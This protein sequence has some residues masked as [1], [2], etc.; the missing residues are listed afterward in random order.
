MKKPYPMNQT[1]A[2]RMRVRTGAALVLTLL[3]GAACDLDLTNPNSPTEEAVLSDPEGL[4]ALAVGM[5]GQYAGSVNTFIRAPAL[6]TDEL[7]PASRALADV[8]VL[9][10]GG[11]IDNTFGT[12]SGPYQAT[13]RITRSANNLI[14]NVPQSELGP[15]LQAGI[16]ALAKLYKAMALGMAILQYEQVPVNADVN[17][18]VPQPREVVLDSV[19][20]LLQS[21]RSDLSGVSNADLA[22]FRQRVLGPGFDLRNTIDAMIARYSLIDGQYQQAIETADRVDLSVLSTFRYS[23]T[24]VNPI[25]NYSFE[26]RYVAPP[27]SFAREAV[28]GDQRVPFWVDSTTVDLTLTPPVIALNQ[29][30]D[31]NDVFPVYLPDEM[32]LIKAEAYAR[33]GQ[34]E[35]ARQLIN[36]VR[37]QCTPSVAGEPV[38][39]LPPLADA[40]LDTPAEVLG[41]VAYE[42]RYE[43]Y[44]QGL[45]WE[46]LRRLDAFVQEEP[47]ATFLPLPQRECLIN[48]NAG[49]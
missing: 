6:V 11:Q 24:D 4:I 21:A 44:L 28:A 5:Q 9:F 30:D 31:R 7:A 15:G 48:P 12:V 40:A 27:L 36:A 39:C 18:A 38:A 20:S 45:R 33:L 17:G 32:R 10:D 25:W 29:Y 3:G 37:T 35:Q 14:A 19:L 26:A 41:Q 49:C 13:Y 2:T 23:G 1:R 16:V 42:R 46:D 34:L 47:K 22:G 8:R 43:L